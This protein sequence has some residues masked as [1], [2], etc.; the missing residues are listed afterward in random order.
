[1]KMERII[2]SLAII[3]FIALGSGCEKK[4][5][6]PPAAEKTSDPATS[7]L[8]STVSEVKQAAQNA[9][10]AVKDTAE[11]V[12]TQ[13]KE[14]TQNV[15]TA[16]ASKV[17]TLKAQ[18]ATLIDKTK[19]LINDKKYDDAMNSLKQLSSL[20]LTPEQQKTVDDLKAQLQKVMSNQVVTNAASTLNNWLKK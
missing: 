13:V 1:M 12:T 6:A 11:K 16:A 4:E 18:A 17:D 8:S 7:T 9:G 14:T 2:L 3:T 15:T 19:A 10:A 5:S 20:T